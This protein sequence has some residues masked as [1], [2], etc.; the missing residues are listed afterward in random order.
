LVGAGLLDDVR[1]MVPRL[2]DILSK[3]LDSDK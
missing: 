2:N 3:A 1:G